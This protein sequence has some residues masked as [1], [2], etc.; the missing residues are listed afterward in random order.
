MNIQMD[1]DSFSGGEEK[2]AK[3]VM[4]KYGDKKY[5][6]FIDADDKCFGYF[7]T[8]YHTPKLREADSAKRLKKLLNKDCNDK[9]ARLTAEVI[10]DRKID[11]TTG[12]FF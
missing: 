9:S 8:A 4:M 5:F 10:Q 6:G 7:G 2:K 3:I 12:S 1:S 11:L